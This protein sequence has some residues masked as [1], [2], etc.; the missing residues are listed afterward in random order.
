M[1][2]QDSQFLKL[3]TEVRLQIYRHVFAECSVRA[4][5]LHYLQ[6]DGEAGR[7]S[8]Q[9]LS[10]LVDVFLVCR[11][12]HVEA[13][14]IFYNLVRF[15]FERHSIDEINWSVTEVRG[16]FP[17]YRAGSVEASLSS[18]SNLVQ[19]VVYAG[20]DQQLIRMVGKVFPGLKC[21][22]FDLGWDH[23]GVD[24][25]NYDRAMKFLIRHR[26]WRHAVKDAL[27]QRFPDG[28][29]HAVFDLQKQLRDRKDD[30]GTVPSLRVVLHWQ[31]AWRFIE[32]I[33]DCD[34]DEWVLR[35]R[36]SDGNSKNIYD[37]RQDP[38]FHEIF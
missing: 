30:H 29:V 26:E 8:L 22:E 24:Q 1:Q 4:N 32:F 23:L 7:I 3:P 5:A 36:D 27:E 25:T 16:V 13:I 14:P 34:L 21:F 9:P 18:T 35:V 17:T 38:L 15:R 33:G 10:P 6:D 37:I 31:L 11:Q 28:M 20:N 12:I 2:Q 19:H